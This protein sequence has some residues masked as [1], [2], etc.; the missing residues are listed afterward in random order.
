MNMPDRLLHR[1]AS[2]L[3]YLRS[4]DAIFGEGG[5]AAIDPS[6]D[7]IDDELLRIEA[8]F[9]Y[10]KRMTKIQVLLPR[11]FELL[12]GGLEKVL[13]EFN[14]TCPPSGISSFENA[15]RFYQFLSDKWRNEPARLPYLPDVA[16]YEIACAGFR[17]DDARD[18]QSR[19]RRALPGS[20]R[21][22]PDVVLL[23]CAYDVQPIFAEV[24]RKAAPVK[25]DTPLAIAMSPQA[26]QTMV[27]EL[28]PSV[29][30]L[31]TLLDDYAD[32]AAFGEAPDGAHALAGLVADLAA[33]G[34]L[35]VHD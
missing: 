16:A 33:L 22:H 27:L 10:E 1:Q 32:P 24:G 4:E 12:A 29:F 7:G 8:R 34:L 19:A 13:R 15:R 18:H 3:E 5:A 2:L 35:E 9:S 28:L 25:R 26:D 17:R 23:R 14:R 20:I 6:L 11:T 30:D 31:L 21:R